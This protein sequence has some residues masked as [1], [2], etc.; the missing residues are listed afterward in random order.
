[1]ST[2]RIK[3]NRKVVLFPSFSLYF[4]FLHS[5]YDMRNNFNLCSFYNLQ[6][7]FFFFSGIIKTSGIKNEDYRTLMKI[8]T[9]TKIIRN[10]GKR[11]L[12]LTRTIDKGEFHI[13]LIP[14]EENNNSF[15][16]VSISCSKDLSRS[17]VLL[18][19]FFNELTID[20]RLCENSN[21]LYLL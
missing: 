21:S 5:F 2:R 13:K 3:F 11:Q 7:A 15:L 8:V 4:L 14:R 20:D 10:G 12:I 18:I 16:R 6:T 9:D 1:M 19:S 17:P